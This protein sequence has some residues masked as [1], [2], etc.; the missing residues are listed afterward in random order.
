MSQGWAQEVAVRITR[1]ERDILVIRDY[2]RSDRMLDNLITKIIKN[3]FVEKDNVTNDIFQ[4]HQD[5]IIT[6]FNA[7]FI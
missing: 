5:T 3:N 4:S 7:Q 1:S 2:S 6:L